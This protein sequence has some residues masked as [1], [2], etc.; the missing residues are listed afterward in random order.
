M[1]NER[2]MSGLRAS[3]RP[4][5]RTQRVPAPPPAKMPKRKAL[6]RMTHAQKVALKAKREAD[7][8]RK[9]D[10]ERRS[11]GN[12]ASTQLMSSAYPDWQHAQQTLQPLAKPVYMEKSDTHIY[13]GIANP[14]PMKPTHNRTAGVSS[15]DLNGPLC[16]FYNNGDFTMHHFCTDAALKSPP[17]PK[18]N[19]RGEIKQGKGCVNV[20]RVWTETTGFQFKGPSNPYNNP[21]LCPPIG[22]TENG[23]M[24]DRRGI[25][26]DRLR[27]ID[28]MGDWLKANQ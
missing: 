15:K 27:K 1:T 9:E 7:V 28:A 25:P 14:R 13:N 2:W 3:F 16:Y 23:E 10:V 5:P 26:L 22:V 11:R 24:L 12:T 8:R 18:V 19:R 20:G 4:A 6:G 21:R 17:K